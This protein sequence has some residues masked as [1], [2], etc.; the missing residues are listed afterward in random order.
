[1]NIA[2]AIQIINQ[3]QE[4]IGINDILAALQEMQ[5][6]PEELNGQQLAAYNV[7][8]AAGQAMFAPA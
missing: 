8:M 5:N 3:Y 1:M 2:Q 4:Q 6:A 7:F